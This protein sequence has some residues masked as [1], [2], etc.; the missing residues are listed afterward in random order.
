[1]GKEHQG[2]GKFS[3]GAR[4]KPTAK[5]RSASRYGN[6]R[7][8]KHLTRRETAARK[9]LAT[10]WPHLANILTTKQLRQ[11]S[12]ILRARAAGLRT[13]KRSATLIRRQK[14][15]D[16]V[17][18]NIISSNR[19]ALAR[20]E[21]GRIQTEASDYWLEVPMD[22][23]LDPEIL[24]LQQHN[25]VAEAKWRLALWDQVRKTKGKIYL[26]FD[27][28]NA[29]QVELQWGPEGGRP[30]IVG[31]ANDGR[32]TLAELMKISSVASSYL[33]QVSEGPG[34]QYL[35]AYRR[36]LESQVNSWGSQA[37]SL[38]ERITDHPFVH[39]TSF[40]LRGKMVKYP[41]G[42]EVYL[43]A[44]EELHLAAID[45]ICGRVE[46]AALH[47]ER[48]ETKGVAAARRIQRY[49]RGMYKGI[50]R[51]LKVLGFAKAAGTLAG[52]ILT[53]RGPLAAGN[54]VRAAV[55]TGFGAGGASMAQDLAQ[56]ASGGLQGVSGFD[57]KE[58]TLR[59]GKVAVVTAV[60][61]WTG[62]HAAR[63]MHQVM[64]QIAMRVPVPDFVR[65]H[66]PELLGGAGTAP[67]GTAADVGLNWATGSGRVPG[68]FREFGQMAIDDMTSGALLHVGLS[69][70][71][72]RFKSSV[73][74]VNVLPGDVYGTGAKGVI[75]I[76]HGT[77]KAGSV[78]SINKGIDLA[79]GGPVQDFGEG[80]YGS[81]ERAAGNAYGQ[82][83]GSTGGAVA[84]V[85]VG[86]RDLKKIVDVRPG[87]AHRADWE[88][89]L[90]KEP[91]LDKLDPLNM[92]WGE[93]LSATSG[94]ASAEMRGVAFEDFLRIKGLAD[95]DT[96]LG[97]LGD[98]LT[99]G[100]TGGA[101]TQ[102]SI[103]SKEVAAHLNKLGLRWMM[104]GK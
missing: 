93:F 45:L 43:P 61:T 57:L 20:V 34:Y 40:W 101:T 88:A 9:V 76:F 60:G 94:N 102:I 42:S 75:T 38:E 71:L 97:P 30:H 15:R 22:R 58:S 80:F 14:K 91:A 87:G 50:G 48:A 89:F 90:S 12:G 77:P 47:L 56:G 62:I 31:A 55:M 11:V 10:R 3:S 99:T 16:G 81:E 28:D 36:A 73:S 4:A 49:D 95:A 74:D 63:M 72:G 39:H 7:T 44:R 67:I 23:L 18:W 98:P 86:L 64:G 70:V 37:Q 96:I 103:R 19:D 51:A 84:E 17:S 68:S 1:M 100:I 65:R 21:R 78:K 6:R 46:S 85:H 32:V 54:F 79:R 41:S 59:A 24:A 25:I 83:R 66:L 69:P 26:S 27:G 8:H 92:S 82:E 53:G 2:E 33:R 52:G 5:T 104:P 13:D 35:M 29:L